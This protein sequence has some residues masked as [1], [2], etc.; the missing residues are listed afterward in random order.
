MTQRGCSIRSHHLRVSR[1]FS[2]LPRAAVHDYFSPE[3]FQS[4]VGWRSTSLTPDFNEEGVGC[5]SPVW[6]PWVGFPSTEG[7]GLELKISELCKAYG[8]D[9]WVFQRRQTTY[10]RSRTTKWDKTRA[11]KR[12]AWCPVGHSCSCQSPCE[13]CLAKDFTPKE[14]RSFSDPLIPPSP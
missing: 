12:L 11:R 6:G 14:A 5:G 7:W 9:L 4:H 3:I 2:P 10:P 13:L 1:S 8:N